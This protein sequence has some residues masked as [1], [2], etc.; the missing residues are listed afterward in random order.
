M[1][2]FHLKINGKVNCVLN[3]DKEQ[4]EKTLVIENT[5]PNPVLFSIPIANS[6][7]FGHQAFTIQT[8]KGK[9]SV[10][11]LPIQETS[12]TVRT[13]LVSKELTVTMVG[14][15]DV[16]SAAKKDQIIADEI[17]KILGSAATTNATGVFDDQ[18][19]TYT[20]N[21][22]VRDNLEFR[23]VFILKLV[24]TKGT[25]RESSNSVKVVLCP[26]E[27]I[28]VAT[29]D[30][31]SEASQ[32]LEYNSKKQTRVD[33]SCIMDIFTEMGVQ[34]GKLGKSITL[35]PHNSPNNQEHIQYDPDK[36]LFRSHFF[37]PQKVSDKDAFVPAVP[38]QKNPHLKLLN[39]YTEIQ[40][41]MADH[42]TLPNVKIETLANEKQEIIVDTASGI[43]RLDRVIDF[44][45]R[46][47]YRSSINAFIYLILNKVAG[48]AGVSTAENLS[49]YLRL[50]V[51]M[52]NVYNQVELSTRLKDINEDIA[53]MLSLPEFHQVIRGVE[54]NALSESDASILGFICAKRNEAL[55]LKK[56][57]Y[58][59][60][61][62]GKGTLDFSVLQFE[63]DA[64]AESIFVCEYRSGIVGSGNAITYAVFLD[65]M[66]DMLTN[67]YGIKSRSI[68]EH[69]IGEIIRYLIAGG[70]EASLAELMRYVDRYK[71]L[72]GNK[73]PEQLAD[74]PAPEEGSDQS[75][76]SPASYPITPHKDESGATSSIDLPNSEGSITLQTIIE[77]VKSLFVNTLNP[78][79]S[80]L[81]ESRADMSYTRAMI[82]NLADSALL[83]FGFRGGIDFIVLSGRGFKMPQFKNAILNN[84]RQVDKWKNA[85]LIEW[86]DDD[87]SINA[88]NVCLYVN[89]MI[90]KKMYDG[91]VVGRPFVRKQGEDPSEFKIEEP[92]IRGSFRE[93]IRKTTDR[94]VD[95]LLEYFGD[96]GNDSRMNPMSD[97]DFE[98]G[99]PVKISS[100]MDSICISGTYYMLPNNG[101]KGQAT[102]YFDGDE[103][104]F[105][106]NGTAGQFDSMVSQPVEYLFESLFP[107]GRLPERIPFPRMKPSHYLRRPSP[108]STTTP[109]EAAAEEE[110]SDIDDNKDVSVSDNAGQ[111]AGTS[112]SEID[113]ILNKL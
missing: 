23:I 48:E 20:C 100:L 93:K 105:V 89:E 69:V 88:K 45:D 59:I 113:D 70:D 85:Q 44:R 103:F 71:C 26:K 108:A 2:L 112:D 11:L 19:G 50:S 87:K 60:M 39:T 5:T 49:V 111:A 43:P 36:H 78:L 21:E 67:T 79:I 98:K 73:S 13:G 86:K 66:A 110:T 61:D 68:R 24:D 22:S 56:G 101:R 38:P 41:L 9:E 107:Y 109:T 74:E 104:I 46:Y 7:E 95:V 94:V 99:I 10:I 12:V 81:A 52:P 83:S 6:H 16:S 31:G 3:F 82:R 35:T 47:F 76:A 17:K 72:F 32:I 106:S 58:L 63:P 14:A 97:S 51:L 1:K 80:D 4:Y 64:D 62:A 53:Y 27:S 57:N 30:F 90:A 91:R 42:F 8:E 29:L 65:L 18:T 102:I 84:I 92:V 96:A 77:W 25:V 34:M 55:G 33:A 15:N 40:S 28:Y 75:D 37:A 54:V